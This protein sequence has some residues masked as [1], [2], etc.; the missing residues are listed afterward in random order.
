MCGIFGVVSD[1]PIS[2]GRCGSLIHDSWESL[3]QRGP[4][5]RGAMIWDFQTGAKFSSTADFDLGDAQPQA[6]FTHTRL[7]IL[8]LTTL[9][10]QPL[11]DS[12]GRY[13]INYNGEVYN[14]T[15][16]R[17]RLI[18]QYQV[19][20]RTSSD[21]EVIVEAWSKWGMK[22]VSLFRGMFAF[23][24]FDSYERK[25]F[26][27][28][29]RIGIKPLYYFAHK[30][31]IAFASDQ[32]T[33]LKSGLVPVQVNWDG[34]ISGVMFKGSLRPRTVYDGITAVP[35]GHI[36]T[37]HENSL[38][39]STYWD[40]VPC[41]TSPQDES[42]CIDELHSLLKESIRL[43]LVSDVPVGTLLSGGIDSGTMSAIISMYQKGTSAFTLAWHDEH[44]GGSNELVN[45]RGV[46][47]RYSL[48]HKVCFVDEDPLESTL[49][50]MQDL[51]EEPIGQLEPH[52]CIAEAVS[53]SGIKVLLSGLGPDETLGGYSYYK[54]LDKWRRLGRFRFLAS[55]LPRMKHRNE[56]ARQALLQA[57]PAD[58]YVHLFKGYL[59]YDPRDVFTPDV[60]PPNW[61]ATEHVRGLFPKAWSNFKDPVQVFNYLDLKIFIGT[62]HNHTSDRFL[63][64]R[65]I[66]GRFPYLDHVWLERA[67]SLPEAMKIRGAEQ[68]WALRKIA[69][70]YLDA[71]LLTTPKTGFSVPDFNQVRDMQTSSYYQNELSNLNKRGIFK[72]DVIKLL[73]LEGASEERIRR[74]FLYFTCF[75]RWIRGLSSFHYKPI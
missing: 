17:N 23:S 10:A 27:V 32:T 74:R 26:L 47:Q 70:K 7:S 35:A 13:W 73:H 41:E 75:E 69:E 53:R 11:A 30:G 52:L 45:A 36:A 46:A 31:Y 33:L 14:Y 40:L 57:T 42:Q 68:K 72:Q 43:N 65:G 16:I 22:C 66:E 19:N 54:Y 71:K 37:F 3:H 44:L 50:E 38:T 1:R 56:K 48:H 4:D 63:M 39:I 9:A 24:I 59:W 58:L 67:F 12:T 62:H 20:F 18:R 49:N 21:T 55:F 28:R 6:I 34:V 29:D 64:C 5:G 61:S 2:T 51:Y 15:D 60:C 8:D 25:L